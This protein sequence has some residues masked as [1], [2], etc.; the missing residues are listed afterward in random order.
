[1]TNP[2]AIRDRH[3]AVN[4]LTQVIAA[5]IHP[6]LDRLTTQ[7]AHLDGYPPTASGVDNGPRARNELTPTEA[8]AHHRLGWPEENIDYDNDGNVEL[9]DD[10][11]PRRGYKPGPSAVLYDLD[12]LL[13]II[14]RAATDILELCDRHTPATTQ[15]VPI[16]DG[17]GLDGF[18]QWGEACHDPADKA[19]LCSRHYMRCYRWR[20]DHGLRPLRDDAV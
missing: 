5:R 19:G 15:P 8:V 2:R 6:T 9:D 1:M 4:L 3:H 11:N 13:G 20:R 14:H 10:G 12:E 7:L 17:R 16:C 18:D